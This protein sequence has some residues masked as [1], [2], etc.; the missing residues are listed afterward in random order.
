[1]TLASPADLATRF[2]QLEP[3]LRRYLCRAEVVSKIFRT[4]N[5][6]LDPA[7]VADALVSQ[8]AAWLPAP[9]WAVV[10][11]DLSGVPKLMAERGLLANVEGTARALG[12]WVLRHSQEYV[13]ANLHN[14]WQTPGAPDVAVVAFPLI[15]RGQTVAALVGIDC[16][17]SLE[18][19]RLSAATLAALQM[20][21]EPAAIALD[22]ANRV[23]RA[24][25]FSVT[26]DLTQLYNSR[27]L[28]QV[29][30][31]EAKCASRS[32]RPLS[33]LF[34]DLDG[35][36]SVNDMHG[37]LCGSRALVEASAIIRESA[38][39]TDI[40][41]RFG[42][43]E[44]AVVLPDTESNGAMVVGDRIR[45]RVADKVFLQDK[46]INFRLTASAGVATLPD[47]A[48]TVDE[49]LRAADD[50][51]CWV[52]AHGKDGIQLAGVDE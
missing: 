15:C 47:I 20:L 37:H 4:V 16:A 7:R 49:L 52:K 40:V 14:D 21:F 24:E 36:K 13:S 33:L 26:D 39:A 31:C 38:R 25:A 27:Y 30:R 22:N 12:A 1:M 35:F 48:V 11:P 34:I 2:H 44:F 43:D 50:A 42:G 45:E 41:A 18:I 23:Q 8:A 19:P 6:S 51:M 46:G 32:G 28:S 10:G 5:A 17:V 29:L 3:T 9:C